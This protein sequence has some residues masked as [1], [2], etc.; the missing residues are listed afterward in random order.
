MPR[1]DN[2]HNAR[3]AESV[4]ATVSN[5]VGAIHPGSSP[6]PG[7]KLESRAIY[8]SFCFIPS[9]RLIGLLID[10]VK[11]FVIGIGYKVSSFMSL[12]FEIE[13]PLSHFFV[14]I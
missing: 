9:S 2:R 14:K 7:T 12:K 1:K 5:T 13:N 11:H 4:D 8:S 3:M 10:N 6:G